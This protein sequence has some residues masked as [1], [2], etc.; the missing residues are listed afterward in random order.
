MVGGS[1]ALLLV[2]PRELKGARPIAK[3]MVEGKGVHLKVVGIVKRVCMVVPT[4][5]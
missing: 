3:A 5:V 1:G 4:S 2:A